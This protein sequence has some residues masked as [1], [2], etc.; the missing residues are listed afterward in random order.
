MII[1]KKK[2]S[3]NIIQIGQKKLDHQYTN[4]LVGGSGSGKINTLL[5]L[6]NHEPDIDIVFLYAK[7]PYEAKYQLPI[8]KRESTGLKYLNDL[9]AF[10]E[11]SNDIDDIYKDIEECNP[12]KQRKEL[13]VFDDMIAYMLSN[14]KLNPIVTELFITGR[15]LNIYFVFITQSYFA[16]P[17]N[18]ILNLTHYFVMKSP[19]K[20]ELQQKAF[21]H[22]S[23]IDFKDFMN[24]YK[25]YSAK[26]YWF[27]LNLESDNSSRFRKYLFKKI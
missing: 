2:I 16:V 27:L 24:L 25:K 11:Y 7:D 15:K 9:K 1:L 22:S 14:E 6:I 3:K 17:K 10:S 18:I 19:N 4:L 23:D 20:I 26:P 5:N 13:I 21:N 12:N 8:N